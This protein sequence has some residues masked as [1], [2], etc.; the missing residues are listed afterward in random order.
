MLTP[1]EQNNAAHG[2][3]ILGMMICYDRRWS[4]AW[5]V[6]GLQGTEVVLCGYNTAGYAPDVRGSEKNQDPKAVE[7]TA[8]FQHKLCMQAHSY[9]NACF[10]VSAGRGG[11]DD[12]KYSM[13]GGSCIV[14][15]SGQI[16]A[17][18]K[19]L[20]DELII[21]N[22]DLDLCLLGKSTT[23]NFDQHRHIEY[24]GRITQQ[25]GVIEPPRLPSPSEKQTNTIGSRLVTSNPTISMTKNDPATGP[26]SSVSGPQASQTIKIL[27][28]NPNATESMTISCLEMVEPM[29]PSDVAVSGLTSPAPAPTA[30]EGNVDNIMSAAAAMRAVVPIAHQYDA[31]LVACYSDHAL[32]RMLREEFDQPTIGIM[33]ASLFAA[34]TLGNR[35][36]LIATSRRSRVMHEDAIRHYGFSGFC[37]G[38][39]DCNLGVLDLERKPERDVQDIMCGVAK[40]LVAM[41]ADSL[42]LG[43]AGMTRLKAA[44]ENAVGDD[45]QVIDG[46][47]AGV[48][49]LIG[50]VRMGGKTAK[51]GMYRSSA[52]GRKARGQTYL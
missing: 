40:E 41:G 51:S 5:R 34:R 30:V 45:I 42:T 36:G 23:F 8:T 29:L 16:L 27:L 2:D 35:F 44:V 14:D 12:G 20:E 25:T 26:L 33:E 48:Q 21:A 38:V 49:H 24:Y 46:V 32:I 50:Q 10:S 52:V 1:S 19:T 6:L 31:F 7:A 47:L 39:R 13:I 15:P 37:A 11:Y 17:E 9:T 4:E 28:I 3:P 18:T 43:C 22:C